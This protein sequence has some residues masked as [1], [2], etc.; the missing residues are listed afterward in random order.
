MTF[1]KYPPLEA[2]FNAEME[3]LP[4]NKELP[5]VKS[6]LIRKDEFMARCVNFTKNERSSLQF[7]WW[8][9]R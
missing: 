3:A 9:V 1:L 8:E 4:N 5:G 6:L 2:D 7:P